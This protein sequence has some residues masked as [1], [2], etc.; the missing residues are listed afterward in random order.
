MLYTFLLFL[1]PLIKVTQ[2][3]QAFEYKSQFKGSTL[4][5]HFIHSFKE[6]NSQSHFFHFRCTS[7]LHDFY[8]YFPTS[9]DSFLTVKGNNRR[10][11]CRFVDW[12]ERQWI[13]FLQDLFWV[14]IFW[15]CH[16][17]WFDLNLFSNCNILSKI[18][19]V[20]N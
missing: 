15:M 12:S 19:V 5:W 17:I 16:W 4:L 2:Y 10:W 9:F 14:L 13:T 7:S 1:F 20:Y 11:L 18:I 3:A 8:I 6:G